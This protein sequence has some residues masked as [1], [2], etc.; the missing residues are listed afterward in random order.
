MKKN[1]RRVKVSKYEETTKGSP[2]FVSKVVM[3]EKILNM[4]NAAIPIAAIIAVALMVY[5]GP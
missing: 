3:R 1:I 4:L 2:E 5:Y